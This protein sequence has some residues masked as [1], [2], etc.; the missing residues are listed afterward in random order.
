MEIS[1]RDVGEVVIL[2]LTGRLVLEDVEAQLREALD[3]LI[4]HGRV[5]LI[6]NL[7][8]IS[9]IDSAGLGFLVS[10]YVSLH[11]SGGDIKLVAVTPRVAHV[12]EI[13]RLDRVFAS[14]DSEESA[15]AGF[16]PQPEAVRRV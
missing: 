4:D 1:E 10:K 2:K 7:A 12:L 16:G 15:L 14:Y 9:Y 13:T 5:S 3:D 6:L 11:R 8:E